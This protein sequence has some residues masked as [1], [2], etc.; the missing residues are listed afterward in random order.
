LG[1]ITLVLKYGDITPYQRGFFCYD[2]SI[3]HPYKSSTISSSLS[4]GI[5]L[6]VPALYISLVE[7]GHYLTGTGG[8]VSVFISD[9][10]SYTKIFALGATTTVLLTSTG[11][12]TIGR[13][14][15]HFLAV[16]QPD[17]VMNNG[18]CG[19]I[20][21]PAYVTSYTCLGRDQEKVH[22]SR[23][24]FPSGHSSASFYSM[25][26]T[27]MYL[28]VRL[29]S[30]TTRS[31]TIINQVLLLLYAWYCALTRISDY[32]H[33]PTDVLSGALLGIAMAALTFYQAEVVMIPNTRNRNKR[34]KITNRRQETNSVS[35][36][37]M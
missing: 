34:R 27:V 19:T 29:S 10:Y 7:V 30:Y 26:F 33:H 35:L 17:I 25:V 28:Q 21:N 6:L 5:S 16:C 13:L 18:T 8:H 14:R 37:D 4:L 31:F 3:R 22:D 20:N 36:Q 12:L 32:K 11:K 15:P 9:W 23:L 2:M 1:S 24:S